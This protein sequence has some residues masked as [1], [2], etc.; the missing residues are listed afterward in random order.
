[1]TFQIRVVDVLLRYNGL[2]Q[3]VLVHRDNNLAVDNLDIALVVVVDIPLK[4]GNPLLEDILP[5]DKDHGLLKVE[6]DGCSR[7]IDILLCRV[8]DCDWIQKP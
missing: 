4:E 8:V 6:H 3:V 1:M 7:M 2:L 5:L